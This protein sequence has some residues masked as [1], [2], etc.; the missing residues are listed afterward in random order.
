VL[1]SEYHAHPALSASKLKTMATGTALRYW[2]K[3]EDPSRK[4]FV[5]TEAMRQGSLVDCLL[6]ESSE[7]FARRY[8]PIPADAPKRPTSVQ[9]NAKK[10]STETLDAIAFWDR[11][12]ADGRELIT[13]E[14]LNNAF[15]IVEVLAKN[16]EISRFLAEA[17]QAPHFWVDA[18]H[19]VECRYKP[20]LEGSGLLDLKKG[21]S[22]NPRAFAAQAYRL[23]Y[24]VQLAHYAEGFTDRYGRKPERC[25]FIVYE[26]QW[27]HDHALI[28][29]DDDYLEMGANRRR[30][31]IERILECRAS[32]V[33]PS[34]DESTMGPPSYATLTGADDETDPEGL[35]LEG[36]Q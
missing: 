26:W 4:P 35:E 7:E 12:E 19:G 10:P 6:T 1:D 27:P 31:A 30:D 28:W 20:D 8:A 21:A 17:S 36:L 24:D 33:W 2:A 18:E 29:V 5:P 15:R 13:N 11:L 32:G 14:W 9:R 16:T 22:A 25:G 3:E 34:H 23:G